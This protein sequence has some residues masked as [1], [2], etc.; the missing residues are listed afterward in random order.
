M[1]KVTQVIFM[2]RGQVAVPPH[3]DPVV[4]AVHD[5]AGAE[6]QPGLEE[7][8]VEQVEDR[9]GV[10]DRA[11]AGGQHHVADLA[12]RRGGQRLL[13]VVL[14]AADDGPED[15]RD[16]A[17]DDDGQLRVGRGLEDGVRCARRGRRRR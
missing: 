8:V 9:E 16:R 6:E 12:H 10:A 4:H 3:V 5:R 14:G 1:P 11:Q 2:T 17:D 13:D 15:Q 7:A